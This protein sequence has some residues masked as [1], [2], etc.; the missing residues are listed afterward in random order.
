IKAEPEQSVTIKL[1]IDATDY[2][3]SII[4][5]ALM[6]GELIH[7]EVIEGNKRKDVYVKIT[8]RVPGEHQLLIEAK[9][10]D[11][12][13][14]TQRRT[15]IL[16]VA[17]EIGKQLELDSNGLKALLKDASYSKVILNSIEISDMKRIIDLVRSLKAERSIKV[18]NAGVNNLSLRGLK[19]E[20]TSLTIGS[21]I[22]ETFDELRAFIEPLSKTFKFESGVIRIAFEGMDVRDEIFKLINIVEKIGIEDTKYNVYAFK[23]IG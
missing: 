21:G 4:I 18:R 16:K 1:N 13:N 7:Q 14:F 17:G 5:K 22:F 10:N 20:K 9:G 8:P 11:P 12:K 2:P 15:L 3:F 23:K 19:S 6:D